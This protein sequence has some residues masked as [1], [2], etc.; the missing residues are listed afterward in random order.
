[1]RSYYERGAVPGPASDPDLA[2][3]L[4]MSLSAGRTLTGPP[5]DEVFDLPPFDDVVAAMLAGVPA[6][7]ADSEEDGVN[8]VLTVARMWCTLATRDVVA[9]DAAADWVL[10]RLGTDQR[11]VVAHARAVYRGEVDQRAPVPGVG[12]R[13][14]AEDMARHLR[15]LRG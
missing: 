5:P 8:V 14:C 15:A 1:M 10:P 2:L 9:K 4:T 11:E 13:T 3:L 7:L 12:A 6:L